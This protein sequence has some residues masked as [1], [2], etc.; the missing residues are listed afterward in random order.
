MLY[1]CMLSSKF[2]QFLRLMSAVPINLQI[3][4]SRTRCLNLARRTPL[5]SGTRCQAAAGELEEPVTVDNSTGFESAFRNSSLF[6]DF[7]M[8]KIHC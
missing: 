7:R 4:T 2:L 1:I 3:W 8:A 5:P 6:I